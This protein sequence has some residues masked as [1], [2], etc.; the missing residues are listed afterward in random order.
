M[1]WQ[2]F[3]NLAVLIIRS[4][5]CFQ[6]FS[7]AHTFALINI[8]VNLEFDVTFYMF[9][10]SYFSINFTV[11]NISLTSNQKKVFMGTILNPTFEITSTGPQSTRKLI[12][13][14]QVERQHLVHEHLPVAA[15][16]IGLALLTLL[17]AY[18]LVRV[19]I[20][21]GLY[22]A[23]TLTNF[24]IKSYDM[25]ESSLHFEPLTLQK[26]I[27]DFDWFSSSSSFQYFGLNFVLYGLFVPTFMY[28]ITRYM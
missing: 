1:N 21:G 2:H 13:Y 11:S 10:L 12:F 22:A 18:F 27:K 26:S 24:Y 8:K 16:Y 19:L 28:I 15:R 23:E 14:L 7:H 6:T 5:A 9:D 20:C 17:L 25:F 4:K 3:C